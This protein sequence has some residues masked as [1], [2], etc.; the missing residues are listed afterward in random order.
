MKDLKI[1]PVKQPTSLVYK[2]KHLVVVSS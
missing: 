1:L 2:H